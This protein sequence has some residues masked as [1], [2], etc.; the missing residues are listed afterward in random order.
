MKLLT[1][2]GEIEVAYAQKMVFH[3]SSML[4]RYSNVTT[5]ML[6]KEV[7][8]ACKKLKSELNLDWIKAMEVELIR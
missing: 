7:G 4:P 6:V 8:Y 5:L 3:E 2:L 1:V